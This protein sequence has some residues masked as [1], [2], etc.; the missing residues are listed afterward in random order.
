M[1]RYNSLVISNAR[2]GRENEF[3]RWYTEQHLH[4]VSR[5]PGFIAAQR[6][7]VAQDTHDLAG[8]YVA[9]YE[10]DTDDPDATLA[11]RSPATVGW[12]NGRPEIAFPAGHAAAA[13][14]MI[15]R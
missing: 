4:D 9:I 15:G 5:V 3:D 6:F 10:M 7:E 1:A 13:C 14:A 11:T 2:A 12:K 8:P